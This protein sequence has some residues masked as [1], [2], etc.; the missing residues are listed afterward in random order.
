MSK[1]INLKIGNKSELHDKSYKNINFSWEE[2]NHLIKI[3]IYIQKEKYVIYKNIFNHSVTSKKYIDDI[4][5]LSV[6]TYDMYG[7]LKF[8]LLTNPQKIKLNKK[9]KSSLLEILSE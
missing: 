7:L 9:D 2:I 1:Q 3:S 4:L 6:S 5:Q 8:L